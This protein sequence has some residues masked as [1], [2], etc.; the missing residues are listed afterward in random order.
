MKRKKRGRERKREDK[1]SFWGKTEKLIIEQAQFFE[2]LNNNTNIC[3]A[4]N[5]AKNIHQGGVLILNYSQIL[6][7]I[8]QN[9]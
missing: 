5:C 1:Q 3:L 9:Y 7:N 8:E 4:R 6:Q 2:I